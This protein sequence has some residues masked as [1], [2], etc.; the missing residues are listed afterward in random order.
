MTSFFDHLIL[1]LED[2]VDEI[3]HCRAHHGTKT[4]SAGREGG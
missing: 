4:P 3:D 2:P 1:F